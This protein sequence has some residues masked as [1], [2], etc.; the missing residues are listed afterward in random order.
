[1]P[2]TVT[3]DTFAEAT[4]DEM[5]PYYEDLAAR[6]LDT[7]S[8]ERWLADWS[9]LEES[10]REAMAL[11]TIAYTTDTADSAKEATALRFTSEIAPKL[12]EQHVR[13]AQ[14]LLD[15]GYTRTDLATTI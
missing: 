7:A 11:A 9:A 13:L 1:M 14:R 2:G 15:L 4:W 8:V 3:P 5:L 6:P 12:G 10:L